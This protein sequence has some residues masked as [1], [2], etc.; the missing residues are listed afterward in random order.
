M[1]V[2]GLGFGDVGREGGAARIRVL[3]VLAFWG[4]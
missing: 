3:T 4:V 1:S 2:A